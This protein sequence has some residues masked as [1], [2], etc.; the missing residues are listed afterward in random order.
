MNIEM[1]QVES[2]NIESVGMSGDDLIVKF[3]TGAT[4]SYKDVPIRVFIE[5][6]TAESVGRYFNRE[7]KGK[8]EYKYEK[9]DPKK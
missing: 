7:V 9:L 4:Y 8:Y 1:V 3:K 5:L 6:T 2:S